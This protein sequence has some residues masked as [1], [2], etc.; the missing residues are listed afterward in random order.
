MG[1]N[2]YLLQ[3]VR[4]QVRRHINTHTH[5][6]TSVPRCNCFTL[7]YAQLQC[8]K[9]SHMFS[10]MFECIRCWPNVWFFCCCCLPLAKPNKVR[11]NIT[12][13]TYSHIQCVRAAQMQMFRCEC[14]SPKN[15][16]YPAEIVFQLTC[17][18]YICIWDCVC[19]C[20]CDLRWCYFRPSNE[21]S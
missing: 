9:Y 14:A 15:N 19:V 1:W 17:N 18:I 4:H 6:H 21:T 20:V 3:S 11:M 2:Y 12:M 5:T 16:C 13:I 10:C 7:C 8:G